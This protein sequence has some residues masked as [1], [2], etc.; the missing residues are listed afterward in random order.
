MI[1]N[2][3][4]DNRFPTFIDK[5]AFNSLNQTDITYVDTSPDGIFDGDIGIV[6]IKDGKDILY[7]TSTDTG[8]TNI[9]SY[10]KTVVDAK[11]G[12]LTSGINKKATWIKNSSSEEK[13]WKFLGYISPFSG[14]C[15]SCPVP[16]T[17]Y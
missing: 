13:T 12:L 11:S 5:L 6:L 2:F 10:F 4:K 14:T 17:T 9:S 7:R 3:I 15:A 8:F 1:D 16:Y